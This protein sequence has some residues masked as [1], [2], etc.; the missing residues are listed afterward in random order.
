MQ[1]LIGNSSTHSYTPIILVPKVTP[2]P[3]FSF[4]VYGTIIHLVAKPQ[5]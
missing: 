1:I 3:V 4:S 5:K 2:F